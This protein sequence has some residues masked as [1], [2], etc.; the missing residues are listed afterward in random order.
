MWAFIIY[1]TFERTFF[2]SRD[3]FGIKPFYYYIDK[4]RLIFASDIPP[5]LEVLHLKPQP[6]DQL[7]YDYLV[8]NQTN[9][10]EKTFFNNIK[11]LPHAHNID[12]KDKSISISRWYDLRNK[13]NNPFNNEEEFIESLLLSIEQQLRSD[14]PVGACLSGGLDSSTIVCLILKYFNKPDIHTF[15]AVSSN[16]FPYPLC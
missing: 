13:V 14:V 12:I 7:I 10:S 1:D 5:I 2:I 16:I 3:R 9:H 15:S 11:K 6:D 8:F 4:N